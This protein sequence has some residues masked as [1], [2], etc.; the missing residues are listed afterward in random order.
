MERNNCSQD[1]PE[2]AD[3]P[4]PDSCQPPLACCGE[5][6]P[7]WKSAWAPALLAVFPK[8]RA[9]CIQWV[10]RLLV[11]GAFVLAGGLKI[12]D[13][14]KFAGDVG[15]YR[16]V[17]HELINLV[18]IL[19]PWIEVVAGAFVLAGVWLRASALVIVSLTAMFFVLI[20]SALVRGL[21]IECGCFGTIGGKHIGL[22]NL[23]IDS[24]L[25]L[26]ASLL[27]KRTQQG[28]KMG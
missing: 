20:V 18:A 2:G 11:G 25:F 23:A 14:A 17:P 7:G 9:A 28:P 24:T 21:N 3:I 22:F 27:A 16:V 15:N 8:D 4:F 1:Q 5:K 26:L 10:L 19:M 12:T 6:G 13:P